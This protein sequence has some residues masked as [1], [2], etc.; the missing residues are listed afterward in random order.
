MN[1]VRI[2]ARIKVPDGF[3]VISDGVLAEQR[4]GPEHALFTLRSNSPGSLSIYLGIYAV[5]TIKF[6]GVAVS[7]Y[8]FPENAKRGAE[9]CHL[10]CEIHRFYRRLIGDYYPWTKLDLVQ[11]EERFG[12]WNARALPSIIAV[13]GRRAFRNEVKDEVIAHEMAHFYRLPRSGTANLWLAESLPSYLALAFHTRARPS[14]YVLWYLARLHRSITRHKGGQL[15]SSIAELSGKGAEDTSSFFY[16]VVHGKGV[17]VFHMLR[18][19]LGKRRF[20][21][22][23]RDFVARHME[24]NVCYEDFVEMAER[25]FQGKLDWFFRQWIFERNVPRIRLH[26][27]RTC[28]NHSAWKLRWRFTSEASGAFHTLLAVEIKMLKGSARRLI[29]IGTQ[30]N[31]IIMKL[32]SRPVS[33][34]LNADLSQLVLFRKGPCSGLCARMSVR[35]PACSGQM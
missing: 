20:W 15:P 28:R 23:I 14:H 35:V 18:S 11:S 6:M 33:A 12:E 21:Q 7:A 2:A 26:A 30:S 19:L 34:L 9:C 1:P 16:T 5:E 32:P 4:R 8:L 25:L 29:R 13:G 3:T 27:I 17:Y 22:L 10:M 24:E 31:E